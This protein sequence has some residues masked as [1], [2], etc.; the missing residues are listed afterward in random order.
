MKDR[1]YKKKKVCWGKRAAEARQD[2]SDPEP[3]GQGRTGT[4]S[5]KEQNRGVSE[6]AT[7]ALFTAIWV[8]SQTSG[9]FP[10]QKLQER[11]P[12]WDRYHGAEG[13][14]AGTSIQI[15]FLGSGAGGL[16]WTS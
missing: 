8:L 15:M 3:V 13:G 10:F 9:K 5:P 11:S 14:R 16:S 4:F 2:L 1:K 6:P 7:G 12:N